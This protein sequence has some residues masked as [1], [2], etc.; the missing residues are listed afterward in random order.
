MK[1]LLWVLALAA[2]AAPVGLRAGAEPEKKRKGPLAGLPSKRGAHLGKIEALGDNE[3]LDLGAPAA[4]PKWGKARGRS[5]SS[6]M[7]YAPDLRGGFVFGEGVHAYVKPDGRYMNDLWFYDANAHR[8]VCLYPG[9]EV[10][11][12]ARRIKEKELTLN[13]HGLL[14]EK[15]GQ[16][17]PPLLIH[18]YGYLGYDPDRRQFAF[19]GSQFGNY[20]TTGKGAVFEEA[21]RL[22]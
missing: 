10:K 17:L 18:A 12:I 21:N 15:D 2:L 13:E 11:T 19:F 4:D 3:W 7:P 5:W 20:F 9:I 6:N 14:V 8:W 16:P 1:R 22:S